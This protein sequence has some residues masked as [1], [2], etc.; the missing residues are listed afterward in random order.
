MI[1]PRLVEIMAALQK[2]E[3]SSVFDLGLVQTIVDPFPPGETLTF[4]VRATGNDY[5]RIV[6]KTAIGRD[7][8]PGA[9][10]AIAQTRGKRQIDAVISE[11]FTTEDMG[12]WLVQLKSDEWLLQ[13]TN[14]T[15]QW[16]YYEATYFYLAVSTPE[17]YKYLLHAIK[18]T[19]PHQEGLKLAGVGEPE[20]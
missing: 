10:S 6:F 20:V 4:G 14:R 17:D 19:L 11:W 18:Q 1:L 8:V 5:A 16:Q 15:M 2:N 12:M 13:I 9:F 3:K 7:V